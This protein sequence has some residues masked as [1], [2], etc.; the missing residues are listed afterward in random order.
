MELRAGSETEATTIETPFDYL[1]QVVDA[2]HLS[3]ARASTGEVVSPELALVDQE[4]AAR[5]RVDLP[6]PGQW[7]PASR[8]VAGRKKPTETARADA[9]PSRHAHQGVAPQEVSTEPWWVLLPRELRHGLVIAS[10]LLVLLAV[11]REIKVM[12]SDS[13]R[14]KEPA[15]HVDHPNAGRP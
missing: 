14:L 3:H 5:A 9:P 10:L 8:G 4:L 15:G 2:Q 1:R 13:P 11:A 12:G 6:D 7:A